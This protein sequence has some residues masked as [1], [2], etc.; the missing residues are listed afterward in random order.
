MKCIINGDTFN[1][2]SEQSITS[3]LESLE[4]DPKRVIVE[5]NKTLIK[6]KTTHQHTVREDA[7]IRIIRICWRRIK[8]LKLDH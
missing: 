8:C 7:S 5:H 3:V 1:F 6:Q 2:D 4:L